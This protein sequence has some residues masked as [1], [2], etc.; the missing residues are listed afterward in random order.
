METKEGF[1]SEAISTN[2]KWVSALCKLGGFDTVADE[3]MEGSSLKLFSSIART[4]QPA[5]VI[6]RRWWLGQ[7]QSLESCAA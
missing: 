1:F 3:L 7:H 4:V 6:G 5:H 2:K